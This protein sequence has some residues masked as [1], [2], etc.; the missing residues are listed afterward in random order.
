M[1]EYSDPKYGVIERKYF[2]LPIKHGG[3][4]A[5]GFTFNETE[6]TKV[7]RWYPKGPVVLQ[8]F[9]CLT[10]ATLGKGEE[11]FRLTKQG[12]AGTLLARVVASTTSAPYTVASVALDDTID[13]GSYITIFGST[14]VCSTGSVAFF[15]D[16]RRTYDQT[17]WDPVA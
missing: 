11:V 15:I 8:K 3:S 7:T 6:L 10:L 14:N 13:A 12:A 17:K 2:S 5:A 1:G 4:A 9:G 16:Y